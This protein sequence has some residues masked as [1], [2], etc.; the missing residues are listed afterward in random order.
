MSGDI[1]L[2][3]VTFD[4]LYKKQIANQNELLKIGSY[5]GF[6]NGMTI[7]CPVDDPKLMSYHVQQ[8]V[9]E[10]GEI[11]SADKRWKNFR[12]AKYDIEEKREEIADLFIVAMN[13]AIFSGFDSNQIIFAIL[14]KLETVKE[15]INALKNE[16]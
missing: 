8:L 4:Q 12:N 2:S 11:L 10:I 14:S 15:R 3:N 5:D 6:K 13:V 1:K 7:E 16:K 9:S